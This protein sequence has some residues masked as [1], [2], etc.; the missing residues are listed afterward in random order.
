MLILLSQ[1]KVSKEFLSQSVNKIS[2]NNTNPLRKSS[3]MNFET[4]HIPL[5]QL[6]DFG[7]MTQIFFFKGF[8]SKKTFS[9]RLRLISVIL[10]F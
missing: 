7:H 9:E 10:G 2:F 4:I 5:I 8:Y 3:K 1:R 6:K